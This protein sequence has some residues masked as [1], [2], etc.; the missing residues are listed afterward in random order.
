[1]SEEAIYS[2]CQLLSMDGELLS[3][4]GKRRMEWYLKKEIAVRKSDTA[5]QL[6]FKHGGKANQPKLYTEVRANICVVCGGDQKLTKHHIVPY[7]FKK[8]FP[9]KYKNRTSFDVAI[10]CVKCHETYERIAD[11]FKQSL[12]DQYKVAYNN[13]PRELSAASTLLNHGHHLPDEVYL[14]MAYSLPE[15]VSDDPESLRTFIANHESAGR[16]ASEL[17]VSKLPTI[18]EFIIA[19]RKHFVQHAAPKY[20]P[21]SWLNEI[22]FTY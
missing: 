15:G 3:Y 6:L 20:M 12:M 21:P 5:I 1:M 18:D 13:R 2:N 11:A 19:W 9:L 14:E 8:H 7:M 17:L 22:E 10:L 16:S 4:I